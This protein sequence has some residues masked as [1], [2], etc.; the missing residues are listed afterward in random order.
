MQREDH[1]DFFPLHFPRSPRYN[2]VMMEECACGPV[3]VSIPTEGEILSS[4]QNPVKELEFKISNYEILSVSSFQNTLVPYPWQL[5]IW[6]F[7]T[8]KPYYTYNKQSVGKKD[9]GLY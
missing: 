8:T 1:A 2:A 9:L 4:A 7:M 3:T 6:L 5:C